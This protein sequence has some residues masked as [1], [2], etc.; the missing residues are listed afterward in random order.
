MSR[1]AD[2]LVILGV[3]CLPHADDPALF[4]FLVDGPT[5]D[6]DATGR[7]LAQVIDSGTTAF[8][9]LSA[10]LGVSGDHL[11][12]VRDQLAARH[13]ELQ[14]STIRLS[15]APVRVESVEL[16]LGDEGR[17]YRRLATGQPSGFYP[18]R[19]IFSVPVTGEDR[20]RVLA[21]LAGRAGFLRVDYR[22][23]APAP[24]VRSTDVASW[25]S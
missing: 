24:A 21:A 25:F 2:P 6:R 13:P 5:A 23:G 4:T 16:Q 10:C 19:T 18:H 12:R 17:D 22:L 9:Q 7:P 20:R 1:T 11:E 15:P 3:V 8:L 14:R